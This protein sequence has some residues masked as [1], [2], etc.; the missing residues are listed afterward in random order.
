M[1]GWGVPHRINHTKYMI[2]GG[3]E[4]TAVPFIHRTVWPFDQVEVNFS[5]M[6]ISSIAT[7][8]NLDSAL[9]CAL[10]L[11]SSP[12]TAKRHNWHP[13]APRNNPFSLK[14]CSRLWD[15]I[16]HSSRNVTCV[17]MK[18]C[19]RRK[20]D[21]AN[22]PSIFQARYLRIKNTLVSHSLSLSMIPER[23]ITRRKTIRHILRVNISH[24]HSRHRR[25]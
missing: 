8:S 1:W 7:F 9:F 20:Q 21:S 4:F 13:F 18:N 10:T 17:T 12:F 16:F 14:A 24:A 22:Y 23:N 3:S 19:I 15:F 11:S 6:K 2:H 5:L 25:K